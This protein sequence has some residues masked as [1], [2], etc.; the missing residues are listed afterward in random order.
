MTS[1][2]TTTTEIQW[3]PWGPEAFERASREGKLILL[4]SGATWCHWCHVM[5]RE[6]YE[7]GQVI[8]LVNE[9]FIPVRID[10]D[11]LPDVD[12]HFQRANPILRSSG[13]GWPLTVL[14]TPEGHAL[15]KATFLPPRAGDRGIG[16]GLVD[17]LQKLDE[18]WRANRQQLAQAGQQTT[19]YTIEQLNDAYSRPGPLDGEI[20]D[21]IVEGIKD[22]YDP[23]HGGFGDAP[24]FFVASALELL[25]ARAWAG[26]DPAQEMVERTLTM[27]ARGGVYDQL[28]G[29]FHRYSVDERWHVPHFEKMGYDNAALLRVYADA[30]ALTGREDF[31][32]VVR[33]TLGWVAEDLTAWQE[34]GEHS[35]MGVSPMSTTGVPP[36]E[37][38][39][40][41]ATGA[42]HNS[43]VRVP[44]R[45]G[46]GMHG[47]DA[48]ATQQEHGR[49][50]RATQQEH[51][52]D[53]RATHGQDA[54]ATGAVAGFY[55]SQDA[56]LDGDDGDFFTW[57]IDEIH[58]AIGPQPV[59]ADTIIAWYDVDEVGDVHTRPGRNVL[60]EPRTLD[61]FARLTQ[62]DAAELR[63]LVAQGK[64]ALQIVR[65]Q[66]RA[67]AIDKTI[68][69]DIN[70]MLID[71]HLHAAARL[72]LT[73]PRRT[74]LAALDALLETHR[75]ER[76]VFGHFRN[77]EGLQGVGRLEDQAWM[78]RALIGAYAAT[79]SER[80]LDAAQRAA[81]YIMKELTAQDG[82]LLSAPAVSQPSPAA[83]APQRAWEDA[84]VRSAASVA[85]QAMID[86]GR[87]TGRQEYSQAGAAALG[88]FA[89][90][91]QRGFGT[92]L[93]GYAQAVDQHLNG[94]RTITVVGA[95]DDARTGEL[96]AAARRAYVP[97]D[98]VLSVDPGQAASLERLG[99]KAA[100][101]PAAY[102]CRA[103]SCLPPAKSVE[104][105]CQRLEQ[106]KQ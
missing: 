33:E 47:R 93:A 53:A 77:H 25:M 44:D 83:V 16:A 97:G 82:G 28:G 105:L 1:H 68:F 86:L 98:L 92:F 87:L 42:T 75:D 61:Q 35:S 51:G 81:Q 20:V 91:A 36:V 84:P 66:R 34:S 102:V 73:E 49:D 6:T 39:N 29:G 95:V 76:G 45:S 10:R 74:A 22:S 5:D 103:G 24:K 60:H 32:R 94:P 65:R 71:A 72:G 101:G 7:D 3:L 19:E 50:A 58:E 38:K 23:R 57:T 62:R 9:R 79:A 4:D 88:S 41:G 104:E 14:V 15:F 56:D 89:G 85:A 63:E 2:T 90:R 8:E 37:G 18:Y 54:R 11:R 55:A 13:A 40:M 27:M 59:Q 70:G 31:A 17:V 69:A 30:Y 99:V 80:Y 43:V 106:L 46:S 67:P 100:E 48:H 96:L 52:R 21:E 78:L 64:A 26:D 12:A